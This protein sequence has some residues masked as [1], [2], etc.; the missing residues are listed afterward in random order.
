MKE[1]KTA[2]EQVPRASHPQDC[3]LAIRS[4]APVC[5]LAVKN[6]VPV[7]VTENDSEQPLLSYVAIRDFGHFLIGGRNTG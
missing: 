7:L 4:L 6:L 5:P 2:E 1:S 3:P